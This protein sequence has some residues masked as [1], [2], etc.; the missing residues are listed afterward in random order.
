[1][2]DPLVIDAHVHI[3]TGDGLRGPWD[4]EGSLPVYLRRARPAGIRGA[5]VMAPLTSDYPRANADIARLITRP[6][7]LG[8]LFVNTRTEAGHVGERVAVAVRRGFC[9]IKVHAHD[10]RITR[11]VAE[12]ARRWALP[13]LYDP[14]GDTA[15]V[16]MVARAYPDVAWVIPHLSSF[17]D[18][19][20]AQ[21]AFV[22]Q[23]VRIPNVFTDTSGV[24]Y[25]DLLEDAV[26]RAGPRKVL[27]GSDGP[28]LHPA[29]ELAKARALPVDRDGL[30]DVLAGNVLRL[31][32]PARQRFRARRGRRVA[33]RRAVTT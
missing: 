30:A 11:E 32:A 14:A 33:H 24:R 18:D 9:G 4:T 19:W 31:T 21:C 13:V 26:R 20:K 15:T 8:Y 2:R 3:G 25:H 22:D 17:A 16:E 12:A 1:M 7:F 10:A 29:V 23:L 27:F 28:F 5:V 6:G